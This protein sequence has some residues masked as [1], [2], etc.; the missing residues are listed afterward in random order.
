MWLRRFGKN[1]V[2]LSVI[3]FRELVR[4]AL[5][6]AMFRKVWE[7]CCL[8]VFTSEENQRCTFQV[9]DK[10]MDQ[11]YSHDVWFLFQTLIIKKTTLWRSSV[12]IL[13]WTEGE[14]GTGESTSWK[15][16]HTQDILEHFQCCSKINI[17]VWDCW[18]KFISTCQFPH[19]PE[20]EMHTL[21]V[22]APFEW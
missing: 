14:R 22:R 8:L 4:V 9:M 18:P 17:F 21:D 10:H 15:I 1:A 3:V 6:S 19:N 20:K 13:K 11:I 2:W 5:I 7:H 12:D 16:Y